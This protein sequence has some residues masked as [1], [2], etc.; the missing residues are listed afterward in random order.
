[1]TIRLIFARHGQTAWNCAGRYQGHTDV[2]LCS[3][4]LKEAASLAYRLERFGVSTIISSR[5]DRAQATARIVGQTLGLPVH[6]DS[7][8]GEVAFGEW[9]GLTQPEIKARWPELLRRWK[10]APESVRFPGGESLG[11]ARQRLLGFLRDPLW[12]PAP[13]S[14]HVLIVTHA[15]LTRIAR[16]E[17]QGLSLASFRQIDVPPASICGFSLSRGGTLSAVQDFGADT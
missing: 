8:L 12:Y 3:R 16:I 14:G 1:M 11:E 6:A 9:E 5:L 13:A 2:P 17:A 4:G 10:R 15:G 7:R